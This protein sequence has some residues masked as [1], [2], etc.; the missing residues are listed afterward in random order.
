MSNTPP[1]GGE[2]VCRWKHYQRNL[3]CCHPAFR[4]RTWRPVWEHLGVLFCWNGLPKDIPS[5]RLELDEPLE[6]GTKVYF[7]KT[8]LY[9]VF[10]RDPGNGIFEVLIDPSQPT[11]RIW[12]GLRKEICALRGPN[13]KPHCGPR[14]GVPLERTFRAHG[15][16]KKGHTF[17]EV[18]QM[19]YSS[20][21]QVKDWCNKIE[22]ELS[23]ASKNDK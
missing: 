2:E 5:E 22:E 18:A 4:T 12:A 23:R 19:V 7:D 10:V 15:L 14:A 16:W 13:K 8:R 20:F 3:A 17:A 6:D 1:K 11:K 9:G 21:S